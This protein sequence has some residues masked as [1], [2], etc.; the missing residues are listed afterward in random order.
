MYMQLLEIVDVAINQSLIT[1][2]NFED[3]VS[4][5]YLVLQQPIPLWTSTVEEDFKLKQKNFL[6]DPDFSKIFFTFILLCQI[7]R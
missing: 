4:S 3:A 6:D 7:F 1:N 5:I 2:E